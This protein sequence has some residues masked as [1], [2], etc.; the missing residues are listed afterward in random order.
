[1]PICRGMISN[2]V[3]A[4]SVLLPNGIWISEGGGGN[5]L[6]AGRE[7]DIGMALLFM[8]I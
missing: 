8:I 5:L 2:R 1:M 6:I 3:P 4:G 7:T